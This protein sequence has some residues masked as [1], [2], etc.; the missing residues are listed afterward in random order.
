MYNTHHL[1]YDSIA[2]EYNQRYLGTPLPDRGSAL[3]DL[4]GQT[5]AQDILEVGSG[6]GFWL[7]FLSEKVNT[8]YGLDFSLGMLSQAKQQFRPLNLLQGEAI[9]LP[10][11]NNSFDLIYSVDA[12]HHFGDQRAYVAEAYRVLRPGGVLAVIGLDPHNKSNDW[13]IYEYF[14]DVLDTDLKRYPSEEMLLEWMQAEGMRDVI[15]TDVEHIISI[16]A[17]KKVLDD[18][19]IKKSSS[20][21]LALLSDETYRAGL[22]KIKAKIAES[23]KITFRTDMC[24]KMFKGFKP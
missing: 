7:N 9:R 24:V 13:Y 1:N 17:G 10:Y 22:A 5:Q 15:S 23:E 18:P 6:T 12:I 19:Y 14:S 2:S 8:A 11:Q 21:Q 3:L 16:H 4:V 20:S